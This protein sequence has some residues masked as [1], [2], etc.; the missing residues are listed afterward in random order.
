MLNLQNT[1]LDN[2]WS[3]A[4]FLT[5]CTINNI[6]N[7]C[8]KDNDIVVLTED[9]MYYRAKLDLKGGEC[10]S[11][12]EKSFLGMENRDDDFYYDD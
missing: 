12:Q 2:E 5:K 11:L 7:F 1:I 3:F 6:T 4:Q 10:K 8:G 9:G